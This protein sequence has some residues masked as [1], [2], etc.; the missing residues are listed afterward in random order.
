MFYENYVKKKNQIKLKKKKIKRKIQFNVCDCARLFLAAGQL[1][2]QYFFPKI[3]I[4][5]SVNSR[6]RICGCVSVC[7]CLHLARNVQLHG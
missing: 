3:V 1:H 4:S 5:P 2:L 6:Y 7:G